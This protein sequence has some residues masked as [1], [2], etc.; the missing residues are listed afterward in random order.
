M[1]EI[2]CWKWR[3]RRLLSSAAEWRAQKYEGKGKRWAADSEAG[4]RL[5]LTPVC[6]R[7]RS[8][9]HTRRPSFP[10]FC[11]RSDTSFSETRQR[12][13][14]SHYL[15]IESMKPLRRSRVGSGSEHCR[16]TTCLERK[17]SERKEKV[18][19]RYALGAPLQVFP[20][21]WPSRVKH[22]DSQVNKRMKKNFSIMSCWKEKKCIFAVQKK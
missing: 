19:R 4:G 12:W 13:A 14:E 22:P 17:W 15:F 9:L 1:S 7:G 8:Q 18:R 3:F 6:L 21:P 16:S 2:C 20:A 5:Q 10:L 11:P